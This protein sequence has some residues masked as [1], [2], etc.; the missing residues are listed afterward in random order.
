M[1]YS[2]IFLL[3]ILLQVYQVLQPY[4]VV[5]CTVTDMS[6]ALQLHVVVTGM[7]VTGATAGYFGY[8]YCYR[9]CYR[10]VTGVTWTTACMS[11][12]TVADSAI[13][14]VIDMLLM[15]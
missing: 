10:Y 15:V 8:R 12:V 9:F 14:T 7:Y 4:L 6:Q 11:D 2:Y 1:C 5:T 13:G 3:Q